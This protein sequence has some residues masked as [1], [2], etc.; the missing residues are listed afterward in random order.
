[1]VSSFQTTTTNN[2]K[3][4][5]ML[6]MPIALLV[7][8]YVLFF[9]PKIHRLLM[10]PTWIS[11][12]QLGEAFLSLTLHLDVGAMWHACVLW[13]ETPHVFLL[14]LTAAC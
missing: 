6:A 12:L 2:Y 9:F 13:E 5:V 10:L 8:I 11:L 14:I 7:V 4:S 3:N 1:M